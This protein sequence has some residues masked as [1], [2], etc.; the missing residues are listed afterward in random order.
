[1]FLEVLLYSIAGLTVGGI[2][3]RGRIPIGFC[4]GM[5][6]AWKLRGHIEGNE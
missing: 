3:F 1:M 5:A 2:L 6:G 4:G